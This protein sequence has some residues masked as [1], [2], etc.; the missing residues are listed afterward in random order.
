[1]RTKKLKLGEHTKQLH[2]MKQRNKF[3]QHLNLQRLDTLNLYIHMT[4]SMQSERFVLSCLPQYSAFSPPFKDI[5]RSSNLI[6]Q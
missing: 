3:H 6:E 5:V 2:G 4:K 1:M